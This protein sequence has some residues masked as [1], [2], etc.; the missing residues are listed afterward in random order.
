MN[1]AILLFGCIADTYLMYLFFS[2]Y[3]EEQKLLA[4]SKMRY[5]FY[6]MFAGI[7]FVS[8]L[9][10]NGDYNLFISAALIFLYF[11]KVNTVVSCCVMY[12]CL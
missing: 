5:L 3:F 2:H 10:G 4:D 1:I 6:I 7:W 11:C 9:L 8:N 12:F